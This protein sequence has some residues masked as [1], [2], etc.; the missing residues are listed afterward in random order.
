M[1]I[2]LFILLALALFALL[3]S[4]YAY[5]S[6]FHSPRDREQDPYALMH[7]SQYAL[8]KDTIHS[9]TRVM[10]EAPCETVCI[11]SFDGLQLWGR[12]YR[13]RGNAPFQ[14]IFHG[15]KSVA[16]RDCAGGFAMSLQLGF[17]VLAVDQRAHSASQGNTIT[18]GIKERRDCLEW[19]RFINQQF[20]SDTPIV[21]SGI[22]M[23]A[24]TVLMASELELPRN[25]A[26]IIA[27]CPYSAPAAI[28]RKVCADRGYPV[29]LTMP[30]VRLGARLFGHF[31]LAEC[32]ASDAVKKAKVPILLLHGEDDRFVPWEMSR[33]IYESCA[34]P[35]SLY[36]FPDAG[37]GLCYMVNRRRYEAA[38]V[39]FLWK[40]HL[41]HPYMEDNPFVE[42]R[43]SVSL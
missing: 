26:A 13:V 42:E 27:D 29:D 25:V 32:C 10:D 6:C 31:D 41:L 5:R 22:S 34:S 18:F 1:L 11:R 35:A 2:F 37:H 24:A 21:L 19:I 30:F 4:Y 12:L 40:I 38:T 15:Y 23:G 39:Q 3:F 28:I 36:T 7:G 43:L 20:G 17:N 9:C 16:V 8:L 14:I 33:K